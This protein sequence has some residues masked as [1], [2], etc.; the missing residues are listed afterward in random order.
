MEGSRRLDPYV[1]MQ[2]GQPLIVVRLRLGRSR[3]YFF[4][5]FSDPLPKGKRTLKHFS[6][7]PANS[8]LRIVPFMLRQGSWNAYKHPN[9]IGGQREYSPCY[10]FLIHVA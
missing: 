8:C 2:I 6:R 4:V 7:D 9:D 3:R 10:E 5:E 1:G